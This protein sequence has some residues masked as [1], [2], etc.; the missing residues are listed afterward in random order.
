MGVEVV[1]RPGQVIGGRVAEVNG[2]HGI[3]L[4][5]GA[6]VVAELPPGL[7]AGQPLRLAVL[8][9][10]ED[11]RIMLQLAHEAGGPAAQAPAAAPGQQVAPWVELPGGARFRREDEAEGR[12]GGGGLGGSTD[13]ETRTVAVRFEG[14]GLGPVEL[15]L[16]LDQ[17]GTVRAVVRAVPG[18]PLAELRAAATELRRA[19]GGDVRLEP[20]DEELDLRA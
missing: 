5:R 18:V 11:G 14:P 17:A 7:Q 13:G 9:A 4:L 12:A 2:R 3:L 19:L 10:A 6:P 1:L 16:D 8:G 20:R 15:R